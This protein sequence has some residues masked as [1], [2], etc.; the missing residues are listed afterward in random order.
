M[1]REEMIEALEQYYEAAGFE[2]I[3]INNLETL[4]QLELEKLYE[5]TFNESF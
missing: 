4:T 1:T 3:R 2:D 5:T